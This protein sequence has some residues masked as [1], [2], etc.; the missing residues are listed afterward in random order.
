MVEP[1]LQERRAV[2]ARRVRL[3]H[4]SGELLA[5]RGILELEVQVGEI[6]ERACGG[7]GR[8]A[9]PPVG[10]RAAGRVEI[11]EQLHERPVTVV[12]PGRVH[13]RDAHR[14]HGRELGVEARL[15]GSHVAGGERL[16]PRRIE[17]RQLAEHALRR[18]G[19]LVVGDAQAHVG[20]GELVDPHDL[21]VGDPHARMPFGQ[22]VVQPGHVDV[23]RPHRDAIAS[24][25]WEPTRRD[26]HR[27]HDPRLRRPLAVPAR[28]RRH[29]RRVDRPIGRRHHAEPGRRLRRGRL[30]VVDRRQLDQGGA[31]RDRVRSR[32]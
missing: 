29:R 22:G 17:R 4:P 12:V 15:A 14:D 23:V 19:G 31:H 1:V 18:T 26:G 20:V 5:P 2:A 16:P 13:R 27:G 28:G 11:F 6:L 9:V 24:Q 25:E 32:R 30:R 7:V 8:D 10:N 21:D 3:R